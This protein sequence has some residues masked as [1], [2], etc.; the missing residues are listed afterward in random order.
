MER[1]LRDENSAD[2][3]DDVM[4]QVKDRTIMKKEMKKK[5][6]EQEF[7]VNFFTSS[8]AHER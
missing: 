8:N 7:T 2:T 5:A 6:N 3:A 1:L 4:S